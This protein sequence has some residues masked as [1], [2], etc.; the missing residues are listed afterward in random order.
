MGASRQPSTP[1]PLAA[2]RRHARRLVVEP[3]RAFLDIEASSGIVLVLAAYN[4]GRGNVKEWLTGDSLAGDENIIDRIP[5]PETRHYVGKVLLYH[6]IYTR[7][8]ING[9]S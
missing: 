3:I 4:G 7:L 9:E 8:Y 6:R 1:R 5:F 2:G